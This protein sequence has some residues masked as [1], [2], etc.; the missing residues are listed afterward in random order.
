MNIHERTVAQEDEVIGLRP[1]Q[2]QALQVG[3]HLQRRGW[4][5]I[6]GIVGSQR[7][8]VLRIEIEE[9]RHYI[10]KALKPPSTT[11]TVPVTKREAS[12]MR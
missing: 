1:S 12:E 6:V 4:R 3:S 7:E 10:A 9:A 11:A 2:G 8:V 5:R